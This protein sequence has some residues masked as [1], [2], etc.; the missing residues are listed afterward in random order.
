MKKRLDI[1]VSGFLAGVM[2]AVGGTLSLS[3]ENKYLGAFLFGI[4]LFVIFSYRFSLF[5]EKNGGFTIIL[6]FSAWDFPSDSNTSCF[7]DRFRL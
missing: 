3:V 4:G 2:I 7:F 5:T 1:L 6:Q